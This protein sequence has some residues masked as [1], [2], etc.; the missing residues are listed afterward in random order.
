[1][2]HLFVEGVNSLLVFFFTI[3]CMYKMMNVRAMRHDML[4]QPLPL[5][6][7]KV[8]IWIILLYEI[9]LVVLLLKRSTRKLGMYVALFLFVVYTIYTLLIIN[10][11]FAYVPCSCGGVVRFLSWSQNLWLNLCFLLLI[12]IAIVFSS[13]KREKAIG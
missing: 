4:N 1:M 6:L 3:I 5:W 2:K 8:L 9:V 12:V 13:N 10:N 7:S 11:F